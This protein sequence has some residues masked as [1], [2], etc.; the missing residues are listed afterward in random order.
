[1]PGPL[2]CDGGL[3]WPPSRL[4]GTH[5]R[6]LVLIGL[7]LLTLA[8]IGSVKLMIHE[9]IIVEQRSHEKRQF[10]LGVLFA[11]RVDQ[12][13]QSSAALVAGTSQ[14]TRPQGTA[15]GGSLA[16][17]SAITST[18]A[19]SS[20]PVK[21]ETVSVVSAS[22]ASAPT[23]TRTDD[24]PETQHSQALLEALTEAL[25]QVF[26]ASTPLSD[27]D[28]DKKRETSTANSSEQSSSFPSESSTAVETS[29]AS[30][31]KADS[32]RGL[33]GGLI[34]PRGE[35]GQHEAASVDTPHARGLS[36]G[37]GQQV[38]SLLN[39]L[40]DIVTQAVEVDAGAAAQL[41]DVVLSALPVDATAVTS[42]IPQVAA[43][44]SATAVDLLPLIIPAIAAVLG[45]ELER[46]VPVGVADLPEALK[47]VVTQG[48][49]I[50]NEI[51]SSMRAEMSPEL[52]A[53]LNQ[54][55]AMV[56]AAA[57]RLGESLCAIG[58]TLQ[59]LPL[60]AIVFCSSASQGP[61]D[62]TA[63]II[64]L[65][66]KTAGSAETAAWNIIPVATRQ[67]YG[68]PQNPPPAAPP[69]S[70][71]TTCTAEAPTAS[72]TM[73]YGTEGQQDPGPQSAPP[74]DD[75]AR[76]AASEDQPMTETLWP[77][78]PSPGMGLVFPPRNE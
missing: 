65:N 4:P 11:D 68:S 40:S 75:A 28:A 6:L 63:S 30:Q 59:G 24:A 70:T 20:S 72:G 45:K 9:T 66:P 27:P 73:A 76:P 18:P 46:S 3:R 43:Q 16:T 60:E 12:A 69:S 19:S 36:P 58:Q 49:L 74:H 64:T 35:R 32:S 48:V 71:S 50:I 14:D 21:T 78:P 52:Q 8:A 2:C 13:T 29:S 10:Q 5:S 61:A 67:A 47:S 33:L 39:P 7:F 51:T 37:L 25:K 44:T 77:A 22:D 54:V 62:V 55:A 57:N 15:V 53:I 41:M 23:T 34:G 42:A 1:M 26:N 56:Y 17:D 38:V 31:S